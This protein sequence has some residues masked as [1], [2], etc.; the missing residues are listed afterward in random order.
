MSCVTVPAVVL[1]ALKQ[2]RA[3][4]EHQ[5][6]YFARREQAELDASRAAERAFDE[7]LADAWYFVSYGEPRPKQAELGLCL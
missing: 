3:M 5:K 6:A 1:E 2:G 7:A 4:R